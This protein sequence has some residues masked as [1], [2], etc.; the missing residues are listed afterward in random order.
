[1][2]FKAFGKT[3]TFIVLSGIVA[4]TSWSC[5]SPNNVANIPTEVSPTPSPEALEAFSQEDP[6]DEAIQLAAD[7][8]TETN[9]ILSQS[10][11]QQVTQGWE[12]AIALLESVPASSSNYSKAQEKLPVFR[13]L[14]E[15]TLQRQASAP[16]STY[17]P[18][19]PSNTPSQE[20]TPASFQVPIK[21]RMGGIPIIDVTFNG[22][23]AF[24]MALDTGASNTLITQRMAN[25]L[26][27]ASTGT[28]SATIA[29]GS[30]VDLPITYLNSIQIQDRVKADVQVAIAPSMSVGLLGQ[31]F[32]EGYDITIR[33]NS[34]EFN[35]R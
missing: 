3:G 15:R 14:L 12:E 7:L 24:E 35:R 32:F 20:T 26:K 16:S 25:D 6:Y 2:I 34:I 17:S 11:L 30:V 21:R 33:E 19:S 18:S 1:M 4:F 28:I 27:L 31:D 22:V 8:I 23:P 10:E 9:G 5:D 29:D 13:S